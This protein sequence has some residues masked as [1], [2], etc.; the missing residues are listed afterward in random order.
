MDDHGNIVAQDERLPID[1][2]PI[3]EETR[4]RA[5]AVL[6]RMGMTEA[7]AFARLL[8]RVAHE[9]AWPIPFLPNAETIEAM[10]ELDRGGGETFDTVEELMADLFADD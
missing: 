7:D 4:E 8:R 6:H 2:L 3:D 10:E 9:G 5:D 1:N